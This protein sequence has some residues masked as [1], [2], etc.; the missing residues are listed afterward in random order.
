VK[1]ITMNEPK[2]TPPKPLAVAHGSVL[3]YAGEKIW[4]Q[5]RPIHSV[6]Q[7]RGIRLAF[8]LR[9]RGATPEDYAIACPSLVWG[10]IEI[11]STPNKEAA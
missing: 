7:L 10:G 6:E 1:L 5:G 11:R 3:C 9:E 8:N 4:D 2:P